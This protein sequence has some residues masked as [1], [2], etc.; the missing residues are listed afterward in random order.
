MPAL[1]QPQ[2]H[3]ARNTSDRASTPLD[4]PMRLKA[5]VPKAESGH[6]LR[7]VGAGMFVRCSTSTTCSRISPAQ[8]FFAAASHKMTPHLHETSSYCDE[9]RFVKIL[10]WTGGRDRVG[11]VAKGSAD[12]FTAPTE[13]R[14]LLQNTKLELAISTLE[15]RLKANPSE[16]SAIV[17]DLE[18]HQILKNLVDLT[19]RLSADT[20]SAFIDIPSF[21]DLLILPVSENGPLR[22]HGA[23]ASALGL[24]L[25]SLPPAQVQD[26]VGNTPLQQLVPALAQHFKSFDAIMAWM[27]PCQLPLEIEDAIINACGD[28]GQQQPIFGK[29]LPTSTAHAAAAAPLEPMRVTPAVSP[30][31][32][33]QDTTPTGEPIL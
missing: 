21:R 31:Q 3:D 30:T 22:I 16:A 11:K 25:A 15:R 5:A 6:V 4:V 7:W 19:P 28:A 14:I 29:D 17:E 18:H 27:V 32:Q 12:G 1:C 2:E 24:L 10:F 20:L 9:T 8:L 13:T 23:S 33:N 26:L